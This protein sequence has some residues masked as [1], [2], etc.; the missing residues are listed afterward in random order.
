MQLTN[1]EPT[2]QGSL[3]LVV[4]ANDQSLKPQ[5]Y[6][7]HF[8]LGTAVITQTTAALWTD[9]RYFLQAEK[10]LSNEWVLM[11]QG[12]PDTPSITEYLAKQV[13]SP[14]RLSKYHFKVQPNS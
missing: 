10:E 14:H 8:L 5:P 1:T 3:G 7:S 9:G 6:N 11:K 2:Y 13:C 4:S 12:F